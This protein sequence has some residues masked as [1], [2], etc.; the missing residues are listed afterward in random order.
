MICQLDLAAGECYRVVSDEYGR[1]LGKYITKDRQPIRIAKDRSTLRS[2]VR[3][4]TDEVLHG[5]HTVLTRFVYLISLSALQMNDNDT[6]ANRW[7]TRLGARSR[8]RVLV[9]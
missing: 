1:L 4:R 3:L 5:L 7:E 2:Y 8:Y 9:F 6:A